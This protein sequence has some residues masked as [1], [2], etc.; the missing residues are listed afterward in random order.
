MS[1]LLGKLPWGTCEKYEILKGDN[2]KSQ[3][4]GYIYS[5]HLGMIVSGKI[6]VP[7]A[8]QCI[9]LVRCV[10]KCGFCKPMQ[11]DKLCKA[12]VHVKIEKNPWFPYEM[13]CWAAGGTTYGSRT[14]KWTCY[15]CPIQRGNMLSFIISS[16]W[17]AF[18][19]DSIPTSVV[20]CLGRPVYLCASQIQ[21]CSW[22]FISPK[23]S[24]QLNSK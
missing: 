15:R 12:S 7:T 21:S 8:E 16:L 2:S 10:S 4:R 24:L 17:F 1:S 13:S 11:V 9:T 5:V 22:L 3:F 19:F 20:A 6:Q 14:I 23:Y 18:P